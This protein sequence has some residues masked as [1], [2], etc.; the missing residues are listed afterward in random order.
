[1]LS[2]RLGL[3]VTGYLSKHTWSVEVVVHL[4][5]EVPLQSTQP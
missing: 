4:H 3:E 1:M 5:E 2:H